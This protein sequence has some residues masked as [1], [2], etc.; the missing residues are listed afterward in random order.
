MANPIPRAAGIAL[1][2]LGCADTDLHVRPHPPSAA[3]PMARGELRVESEE[4]LS[5]GVLVSAG[6]ALLAADRLTNDVWLLEGRTASLQLRR[7]LRGNERMRARL[8]AISATVDE[9]RLL[10]RAGGVHVFDRTDWSYLGSSQARHGVGTIMSAAPDGEGGFALLVRRR[11]SASG[12]VPVLALVLLAA[13]GTTQQAWS[14]EAG[15]GGRGGRGSAGGA[16]SLA[17]A[18]DGWVVAASEPPYLLR[19][20]RNGRLQSRQPFLSLPGRR[21]SREVTALFQRT[22]AAA[23]VA[24]SVQPPRYYPAVTSLRQVGSALLAVPYVGGDTGE[25]QGLDVYCGMRYVRTVI[26]SPDVLQV[27]LGEDAVLVVSQ[28]AL[29]TFSLDV[30]RYDDLPLSCDDTQ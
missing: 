15:R 8:L 10:D 13:D 3:V 18:P 5:F 23:G 4:P 2:V 27:L 22:A 16:V 30:Y 9:W 28:P 14:S 6:D 29:T 1:L 19:F 17:P 26:D 25:A 21:V 24:G 11:P 20:D 7:L 12:D